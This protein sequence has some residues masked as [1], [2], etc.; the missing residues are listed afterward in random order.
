MCLT[1]VFH[2]VQNW[3][4]EWELGVGKALFQPRADCLSAEILVVG[5]RGSFFWPSFCSELRTHVVATLQRYLQSSLVCGIHHTETSST[6]ELFL[7]LC[8]SQRRTFRIRQA[9]VACLTPYALDALAYGC[10]ALMRVIRVIRKLH[11]IICWR[12]KFRGW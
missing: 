8:H 6:P 11:Y 2:A 4:I 1:P 10:D 7:P 5:M 12:V 9:P 3:L